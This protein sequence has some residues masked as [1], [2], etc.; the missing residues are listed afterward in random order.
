MP[1]SP[2]YR[3]TGRGSEA[4]I[5]AI[6][7]GLKSFDFSV[8]RESADALRK[9]EGAYLHA[10]QNA[11]TRLRINVGLAIRNSLDRLADDRAGRRKAA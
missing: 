2:E 9:Q 8:D 10:H 11:V 6:H 1:A 3:I 4:R 7:E 5:A